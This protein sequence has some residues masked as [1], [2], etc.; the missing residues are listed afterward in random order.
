MAGGC[1]ET[2]KFLYGVA[3]SRRIK[4]A[5]SGIL[6][7]PEPK[8]ILTQNPHLLFSERDGAKQIAVT[9]ESYLLSGLTDQIFL[10][11]WNK[12]NPIHACYVV[13]SEGY[14]CQ[15]LKHIVTN[16]REKGIKTTS[17]PAEKRL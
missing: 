16:K 12:G 5:C 10:C 3:D 9:H 17:R 11:T 2:I 8:G 13:Y 7:D 14:L 1:D 6:L 4:R 15:N